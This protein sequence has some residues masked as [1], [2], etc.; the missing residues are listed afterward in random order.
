MSYTPTTWIDRNVQY[1]NR[2]TDELA[3]VKTFTES[4]GTIMQAGTAV[5]A[6]NLNKIEV[7]LSSVSPAADIYNYFNVGGAL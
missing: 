2:Y 5:N 3:N 7:G 4:P 1:P 6:S